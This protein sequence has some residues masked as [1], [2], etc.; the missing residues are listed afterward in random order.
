MRRSEGPTLAERAAA[1]QPTAPAEQ[2][3]ETPRVRVVVRRHCWVQ[4]LPDQPRRLPG[5]LIEWRQSEQGG[6]GVAWEGRV[7]YVLSEQPGVAPVLVEAWL[8]AEHLTPA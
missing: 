2:S 6:G 8:A 3:T 1:P 5:L 7:V 4:G